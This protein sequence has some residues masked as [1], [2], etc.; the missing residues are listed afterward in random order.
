MYNIIFSYYNPSLTNY[1]FCSWI[2]LPYKSTEIG[3]RNTLHGMNSIKLIVLCCTYSI[4][5]IST[6]FDGGRIH[7]IR[8]L[9]LYKYIYQNTQQLNVFPKLMHWVAF[10]KVHQMEQAFLFL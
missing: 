5:H 6:G 8:A 4:M 7:A 3:G 1:E 2:V 10:E 9:A